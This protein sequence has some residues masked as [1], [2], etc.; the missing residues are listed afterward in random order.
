MWV[1]QPSLKPHH[2]LLESA[3][4]PLIYGRFCRRPKGANLSDVFE[5][6]NAVFV[7][8]SNTTGQSEKPGAVIGSEVGTNRMGPTG[9]F[10]SSTSH[11]IAT[12]VGPQRSPIL[13]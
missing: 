8:G 6:P 9:L 10:A 7:A 12:Q 3:S 5:F 2:S 13:R 11:S 1:I 4:K